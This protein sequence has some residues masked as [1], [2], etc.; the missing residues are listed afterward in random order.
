[1]D[2]EEA[3]LREQIF[4]NNVREQIVSILYLP[5]DTKG[6]ILGPLFV[7]SLLLSWSCSYVFE[8]KGIKT[9]PIW[10]CSTC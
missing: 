8:N 7:E 6:T 3:D 10:S 5:T 9:H 2:D 1:M 4:H